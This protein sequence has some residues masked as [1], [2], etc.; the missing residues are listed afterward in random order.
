[1]AISSVLKLLAP[2]ENTIVRTVKAQFLRHS[3]T[4]DVEGVSSEC[5]TAEWTSVHAS[6]DLGRRSVSHLST[7]IDIQGH[8]DH[9]SAL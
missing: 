6:L 9:C 4:I 7:A 1:M 2:T 5:T 3:F 8:G